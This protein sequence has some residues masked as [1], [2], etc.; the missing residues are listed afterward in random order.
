MAARPKS[1]SG[2][3]PTSAMLG[4]AFD[5]KMQGREAMQRDLDRLEK[6]AHVNLKRFNKAKCKVLHLG[7]A[8][9]RCLYRLGKES[10]ESSPVEKDFRV[11]VDEKP[12]MSQQC[13]LAAQK[14][15]CILSCINKGVVSRERQGGRVSLP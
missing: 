7:Q 14:A 1:T 2:G 9:P 4:L 8:N 3:S 6:W 10:L 15:N 13:A 11:L 5:L 12:D